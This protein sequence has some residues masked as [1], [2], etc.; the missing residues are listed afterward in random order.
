MWARGRSSI[1][2]SDKSIGACGRYSGHALDTEKAPESHAQNCQ[3]RWYVAHTRARHEKCVDAQ[4][5]RNAI[6]RF[7]PLA[8]SVRR[9]KDRRMQLKL[10]LFPGYVFVRIAWQERM[11]V[12]RIPSVVRLVGFNGVPAILDDDEI[13][14]LRRALANGV[15]AE[16]H[17]YLTV[18]RRVRICTGPLAGCEGI[19]R[20]WKGNLRVVLSVEAIQRS[21]S[22][23]VDASSLETAGP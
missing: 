21:I 9:W 12:L 8:E 15:Y 2:K 19:L 4:L 23:D 3:P 10:P 17:R 7:L 5:G 6:E 20:R 22:V 13:E 1:L 18:G 16:P 14:R 11:R